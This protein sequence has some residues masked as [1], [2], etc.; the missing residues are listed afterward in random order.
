MIARLIKFMACGRVRVRPHAIHVKAWGLMAV[1]VGFYTSQLL[2][3]LLSDTAG[4]TQTNS[5]IR[6]SIERY[7]GWPL[8]LRHKNPGVFQEF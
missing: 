8:Y 2:Y 1:N 4:G 5:V 7:T 6:P 3:E